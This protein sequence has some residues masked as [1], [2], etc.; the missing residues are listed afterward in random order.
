MV[1]HTGFY[2]CLEHLQF[3]TKIYYKLWIYIFHKK[4]KGYHFSKNKKPKQTFFLY[5]KVKELKVRKLSGEGQV[6]SSLV[7]QTSSPHVHDEQLLLDLLCPPR[8]CYVNVPTPTF[9]HTVRKLNL[10]PFYLHR[11]ESSMIIILCLVIS[12]SPGSHSPQ[13]K[14]Y[15]KEC[16][17][18]ND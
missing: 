12:I 16:L 7:T 13:H 4:K 9:T 15:L 2:T 3:K 14:D 8:R 17:V 10:R 11:Q 6:P 1:Y 5:Y 18:A